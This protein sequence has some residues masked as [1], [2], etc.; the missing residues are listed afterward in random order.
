MPI[1]L[2]ACGTLIVCL[3]FLGLMP[4]AGLTDEA[5]RAIPLLV[6]GWVVIGAAVYLGAA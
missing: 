1:L 2:G 4:W 6:L 3:S 5:T